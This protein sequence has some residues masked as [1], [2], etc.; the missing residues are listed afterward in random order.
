MFAVTCPRHRR[1]VLLS[2]SQIEDVHHDA[3]G[4]AVHYHCTCGHH[5]VWRT[6]A[7]ARGGPPLERRMAG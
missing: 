6:G 4:I 3:D 5:G 2:L 1:R 7:A